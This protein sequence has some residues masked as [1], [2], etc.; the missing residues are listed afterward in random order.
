MQ[1]LSEAFDSGYF[2]DED[3]A[4]FAFG[5]DQNCEESHR[6]IDYESDRYREVIGCD[7]NWQ[8]QALNNLYEFSSN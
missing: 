1:D 6:K 8:M 5:L 3:F 7:A 4:D 2:S